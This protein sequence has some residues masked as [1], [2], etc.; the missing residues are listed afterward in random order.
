M[1][2]IVNT[3][4]FF[5]QEEKLFLMHSSLHFYVHLPL[6]WTV[7][8]LN[9]IILIILILLSPFCYTAPYATYTLTPMLPCCSIKNNPPP[10]YN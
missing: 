6:H 10:F 3:L 2:K 9:L 1:P 5:L 8:V 7:Y 4:C